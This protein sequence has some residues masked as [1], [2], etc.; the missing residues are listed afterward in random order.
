MDLLLRLPP[1]IVRVLMRLVHVADAFG[2]LPAS[3]IESDPMCSSVFVANLGSVGLDAGYHHLW[4]HGTCPIFCVIG[5]IQEGPDGRRRA[6]L[7]WSY[8]ERTED[9]LYC[10]A[11]LERIRE[12]IESPQKLA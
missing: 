5:G 1:P 6:V 7:K 4:E 2:L 11:G 12:L 9:G 8:D 10:A 3:M